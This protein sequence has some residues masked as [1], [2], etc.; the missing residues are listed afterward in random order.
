MTK[1]TRLLAILL[2]FTPLLAVAEDAEEINR[3][4]WE[5]RKEGGSWRGK[6]ADDWVVSATKRNESGVSEIQI[7]SFPGT[8]KRIMVTTHKDEASKKYRHDINIPK[9]FPFKH[10]IKP[11][12][13]AGGIVVTIIFDDNSCWIMFTEPD[14]NLIGINNFPWG[15]KP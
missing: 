13:K 14:R 2:V 4:Q 1:K 8:E 7:I 5:E 12:K 9:G 3:V 15:D 10:Q 6:L 11:S